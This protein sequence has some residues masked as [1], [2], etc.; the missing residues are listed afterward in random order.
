MFGEEL[1][2]ATMLGLFG[3]TVLYFYFYMKIKNY[4]ELTSFSL[5]FSIYLYYNKI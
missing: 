1:I 4:Q 3:G 2:G 5:L